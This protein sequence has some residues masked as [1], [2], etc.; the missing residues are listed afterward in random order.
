MAHRR[1]RSAGRS[2]DVRLAEQD[3][4]VAAWFW[5]RAQDDEERQSPYSSSLGRWCG[6]RRVLDCQV[7]QA[8]LRLDLA[9]QRVLVQARAAPP[10]R[11][12]RDP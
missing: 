6:G 7:V 5:R 3:V 4:A 12:R 2:N 11:T 8:E 10:R 9:Q 1:R